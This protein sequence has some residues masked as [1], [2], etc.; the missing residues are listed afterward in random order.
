MRS[1]RNL[2]KSSRIKPENYSINEKSHLQLISFFRICSLNFILVILT[3]SYII[4]A[5][6]AAAAARNC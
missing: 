2:Q 3:F 1:I 6:A 5:K 4:A